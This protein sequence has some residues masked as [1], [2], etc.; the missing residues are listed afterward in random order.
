MNFLVQAYGN[1]S[2]TE[3]IRYQNAFGATWDCPQ[4]R[5]DNMPD[6]TRIIAWEAIWNSDNGPRA[7]RY[8]ALSI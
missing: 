4:L 5:W 1:P 7:K 6:G 2:S 3:E 8:G